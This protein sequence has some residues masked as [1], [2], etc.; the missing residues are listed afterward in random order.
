MILIIVE[1]DTLPF[2]HVVAWIKKLIK[3]GYINPQQ[4][5]IIQYNNCTYIYVFQCGNTYCLLSKSDFEKL[6]SQATS[7]MTYPQQDKVY[8]LAS[9]HYCFRHVEFLSGK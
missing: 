9:D 6:S 7:V 2:I 8:V 5:V 4:K 1:T 3:E